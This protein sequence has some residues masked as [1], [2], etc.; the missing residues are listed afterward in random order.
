MIVLFGEYLP[1]AA[2]ITLGNVTTA[3]SDTRGYG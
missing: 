1:A 3:P 2:S